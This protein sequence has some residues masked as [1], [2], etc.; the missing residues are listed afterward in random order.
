MGHIDEFSKSTAKLVLKSTAAE[1]DHTAPSSS[2]P[3]TFQGTSRILS[4]PELSS[5]IRPNA[6]IRCTPSFT[7]AGPIW[8]DANG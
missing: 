1:L 2:L 3:E 5:K 6:G 8:Y 4:T 7:N